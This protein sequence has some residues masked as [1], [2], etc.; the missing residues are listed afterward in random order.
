MDTLET[1]LTSALPPDL[2]SAPLAEEPEE[3]QDTTLDDVAEGID[4]SIYAALVAS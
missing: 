4:R 1:L 2:S 3:D